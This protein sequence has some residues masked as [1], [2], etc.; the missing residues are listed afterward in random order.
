MG[1]GT[2]PEAP[3]IPTSESH[4]VSSLEGVWFL[5]LVSLIAHGD[6]FTSIHKHCQ[7]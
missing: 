6:V 2:V 7:W 3:V 1:S 4:E 5:D